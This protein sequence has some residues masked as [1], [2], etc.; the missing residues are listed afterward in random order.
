MAEE[1]HSDNG[2]NTPKVEMS[3]IFDALREHRGNISKTA[4]ELGVARNYIKRRIDGSVDLQVFLDDIRE[5]LV[6]RAEDNVF[7]DVE[8]NDPGASRFVLATLGKTRG[9]AQ[10]V[11]GLGK[12]GAI[13]VE[14]RN[15]AP[16]VEET[17]P[18]IV[19]Q[20]EGQG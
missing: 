2:A 9:W 12:D 4:A 1:T 6:D 17:E 15:F 7:A 10:G 3:A 5:S 16:A 20:S 19:G 11:A 13:T 8:K 18:A 14:V